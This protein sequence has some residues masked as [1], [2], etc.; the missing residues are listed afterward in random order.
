MTENNIFPATFKRKPII[1]DKNID[2]NSGKYSNELNIDNCNNLIDKTYKENKTDVII[3]KNNLDLNLKVETNPFCADIPK[4]SFDTIKN[5]NLNIN[6]DYN[7]FNTQQITYNNNSLSNLEAKKSDFN[8]FNKYNINNETSNDISYNPFQT[9]D[10]KNKN[11]CLAENNNNNFLKDNTYN[12]LFNSK[13]LDAFKQNTEKSL[14]NPF[15]NYISNKN[16]TSNPFL[17]MAAN[18][19]NSNIFNNQTTINPLWE[20]EEQDDLEEHENN[21][22]PEEEIEIKN[23]KSDKA[24]LLAPIQT[25]DNIKCIYKQKIFEFYVFDSESKKYVSKGKG[26]LSINIIFENKSENKLTCLINFKN[27]MFTVLFEA[28]LLLDITV[29]EVGSSKQNMPKLTIKNLVK[30]DENKTNKLSSI[31]LIL[32]NLANL[33]NTK[34]ALE[35]ANSILKNKDMSLFGNLENK[36]EKLITTKPKIKDEIKNI[37]NNNTTISNIEIKIGKVK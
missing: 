11:K 37:Q 4:K 2:F 12:S 10:T 36:K 24:I 1:L 17:Q 16:T 33:N 21:I 5:G 32:E 15:L 25:S 35:K 31:I 28:V 29:F 26:D 8:T 14:D 9:S 23:E 30:K 18:N 13:P 20:K 22:N 19:A 34:E 6:S 7:P 3:N 27:S